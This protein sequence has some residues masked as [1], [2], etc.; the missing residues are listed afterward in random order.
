MGLH[1]GY[2]QEQWGPWKS[3][4]LL[5][6][7]SIQELGWQEQAQMLAKVFR[8]HGRE[9]EGK[10]SKDEFLTVMQKYPCC[11]PSHHGVFFQLFDRDRD[12]FL[13]EN[14]FVGGM[15]SV[16]PLTPHK[17]EAPSGQLRMQFIFLYYDANRNG[18]LEVEEVARMI[19]HI[20]QVRVVL[21]QGP[22]LHMI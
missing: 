11:K 17:L 3:H 13:N 21:S 7:Q 8:E 6:H 16:S 10:L 15:L 12:G 9:R 4:T 1:E 19:E 18:R 20:Q 2:S 5:L 22:Q 14:D